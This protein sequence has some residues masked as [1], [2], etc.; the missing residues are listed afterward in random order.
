MLLLTNLVLCFSIS[1]GVAVNSTETLPQTVKDTINENTIKSLNETMEN[2]RRIL[3][4]HAVQDTRPYMV[5]LRPASA[6]DPKISETNW[7]CGGV[8][9]HERY[10]LTSAACIEDA[11]HFYV[12][13]GLH[14]W[15]PIKDKH[16]CI[17][18]GA[19][20]AVWK[21]V[22]KS[23]YFDGDDFDNIRWMVGDIA[24]VKTE[25][26]FNFERRIRGCDFIPKKIDFNNRSLELE[27]PGSVGS[28]AGWGSTD[29]FGDGALQHSFR[30]TINSPE[31]LETDT[32]L[33]S[34]ANCK[35]RWE[36]RYHFIIDEHVI[37][38][39][40]ITDD[41]AMASVCS[42]REVNCKELL[43]SD[44]E[45]DEYGEADDAVQPERRMMIE[46]SQLS[47]H[48]A[49]HIPDA[50]RTHKVSSGGFCENDH[51][52]PLIVGQGKTA[53]VV[54]VMSACLTR[55]VTRKCYGPFLFTSVY[56]YR[57]LITCAIDK[58]LGP[59]CRKLLRSS[60]TPIIET[61][62]D[63]SNHADGPAKEDHAVHRVHTEDPNKIYYPKPLFTS[64]H[65]RPVTRRVLEATD[66]D[67]SVVL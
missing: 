60:K 31:L 48:T 40:D 34:K 14:K 13:S 32:Q 8:I 27:K 55:D 58:D 5:Y 41:E 37:C 4:G 56:R 6:A 33:I 10:I 67:D 24:V 18:N 21:C 66:R 50:R 3:R 64:T 30:S 62:F 47:I 36:A 65:F 1:A 25:D 17:T 49:R 51:G 7:L 35:K 54:G 9:I 28:I 2:T 59:T 53:V 46:P 26:N 11:K 44:D 43:Y 16:E 57:N 15:V 61:N 45:K 22:P 42:E 39:R 20:K 63:W 38:T 29:S 52:G 23:Y 12:V 19:K